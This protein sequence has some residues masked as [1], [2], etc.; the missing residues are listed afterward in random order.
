M[1]GYA[2]STAME[3]ASSVAQASCGLRTEASV[4]Q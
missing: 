2:I 4:A 1:A 3:A